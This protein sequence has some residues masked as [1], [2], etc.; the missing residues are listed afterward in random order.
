MTFGKYLVA[1]VAVLVISASASAASYVEINE[2]KDGKYD[3]TFG[4]KL[5]T[6]VHTKGYA[7]PILYPIIGPQGIR[8]TRD[9]PMVKGTKDERSDHPHH[10]SLWY[11]H[12]DVNGVSFWHI[13]KDTG[14]IKTVSVKTQNKGAAATIDLQNQWNDAKGKTLLTDA[15]SITFHKYYAINNGPTVGKRDLIYAMIDYQITLKATEGDVTFGDTK[16]GTMGIRTHAML[17]VNK[18]ATAINSEGVTGKAVWGKAAAWVDYSNKID[19]KLVGIAIFDHPSNPRHPS[20]W[21]ARDYGLVA[22]NPFGYSYFMKKPRGTGNL[23]I[24]KGDSV[25]FKYR[26]LFH[27]GDAKTGQVAKRYKEWSG[28]K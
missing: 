19:G 27:E 2:K 26:F 1:T 25:T 22:A 3:V 15:Q 11:T 4:G 23:K 5:F 20:T 18:G 16:E 6:T 9:Y 24:K 10:Q 28:G 12:G 17:R 21:H 14:T 13:G 7:K 8:M